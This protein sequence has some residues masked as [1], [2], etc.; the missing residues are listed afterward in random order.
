MRS[1]EMPALARIFITL[2]IIFLVMGGLIYFSVSLHLPLGHLPGDIHIHGKNGDFY[3]PL[4]TCILISII[5]TILINLVL[6]IF[7]K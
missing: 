1:S 6:G 3:F 7:K 2:G 4:A 5:I